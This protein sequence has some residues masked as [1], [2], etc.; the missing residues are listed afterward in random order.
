MSRTRIVSCSLAVVICA[1]LAGCAKDGKG[2]AP[3]LKAPATSTLALPSASATAP[4]A[5]PQFITKWA[6]L[7]PFTFGEND[8]GGDPQTA[9]IDKE[10]MPKE[11]ALNGTQQ[12][13]AGSSATWKANDFQDAGGSVDLDAFYGGP[14]HAA[15]YA[16]AWVVAPEAI[17]DAT[18]LVG[19][20]DYIK[21]WVNGKLV[22]AYNK[23][24][25]AAE[26]D[27][28]VV[29]G[30]NLK[31]GANR[32]VVKCTDVVLGWNYYLRFTTK[33]GKPIGIGN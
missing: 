11:A 4:A 14:E 29:E 23:E 6:L 31:K 33:D 20:D 25:R 7:G 21:V 32:I 19:S 9:S 26:A 3:A 2:G 15:A 8:F 12:P 16:V 17:K 5:Q 1:F 28:D 30:V 22:H 18:L 27:Q 13:P 10:F 24:R